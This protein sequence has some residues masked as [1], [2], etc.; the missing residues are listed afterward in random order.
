MS[1]V[2]GRPSVSVAPVGLDW[3]PLRVPTGGGTFFG[4]YPV[5]AYDSFRL[6]PGKSTP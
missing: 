3:D 6:T 2:P 1:K 4:K 5:R